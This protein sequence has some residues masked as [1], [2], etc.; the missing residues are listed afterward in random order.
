MKIWFEVHL[1]LSSIKV[2][3]NR[4]LQKFQAVENRSPDLGALKTCNL[5]YSVL[6]L[7]EAEDWE[8]L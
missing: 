2:L 8:I 5:A 4:I 3:E 1:K 6:A 7:I